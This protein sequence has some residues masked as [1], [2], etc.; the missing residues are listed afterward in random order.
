[1]T[2]TSNYNGIV[3]VFDIDG[4]T[5]NTMPKMRAD[6]KGAFSR[7]GHIV[8][9]EQI[10]AQK[11]WYGLAGQLGINQEDYDR[12]F[13][14]R[15]S[16]EQSLRDGEAPLFEDTLPCFELLLSGGATLAALT[17]SSPEYT[18]AKLDYHGLYQYFGDR[19]AVTDIKS[20]SKRAE[21]L[22]LIN[23][24][25]KPN[26]KQAYFIG[27][28]TE[29][30]IVASDVQSELYVPSQR[31]YLNRERKPVPQEVSLYPTINSLGELPEVIN[32]ELRR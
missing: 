24:I 14:K 23:Q 26:I 2:N 11:G 16:W 27:D 29:D 4:T 3:A 6:I 25:G 32:H 7:L 17:K 22:Q 9:D 31:V 8:A 13:D 10:A 18:R 21:A 5:L 28:R 15:K 1:M 12:E 20:P 30:V 19:V